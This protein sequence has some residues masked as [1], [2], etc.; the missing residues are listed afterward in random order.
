MLKI[1]NVPIIVRIINY[2]NKFGFDEFIIATGY[3]KNVIEN[4]LKNLKNL[5]IQIVDTGLN[6]MTGGRVKILKKYL[7]ST[8]LL[9]EMDYQCKYQGINTFS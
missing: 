2:Y 3:K 1:K 8:F 9:M 6:S 7:N 4:F 5:K